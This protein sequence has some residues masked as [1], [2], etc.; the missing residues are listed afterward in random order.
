MV[1]RSGEKEVKENFLLS[2][3]LDPLSSAKHELELGPGILEFLSISW[4]AGDQ[5][6]QQVSSLLY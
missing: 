2:L 3:D 5:T 4:I 6:N 1:E